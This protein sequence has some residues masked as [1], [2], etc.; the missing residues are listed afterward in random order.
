MNH[1]IKIL[2]LIFFLNIMIA[3]D[4]HSSENKNLLT[5]IPAEAY[6]LYEGK[7]S[8]NNGDF[9]KAISLFTVSYEKLPLLADYALLWR[10]EAYEKKGDLEL[11]IDDLRQLRENFKD[12]IFIKN[13]RK[14]ELQLNLNIKSP[15]ASVLLKKY[16]NDY[17]DDMD[18]KYL[19]ADSQ[20]NKGEI[21]D[22]KKIFKEIFLSNSHLSIAARKELSSEDIT[23]RDLLKKGENLNKAYLFKEAEKFFREALSKKGDEAR[24]EIVKGLADSLFRQKRYK[25]SGDL[26]RKIRNQYWLARSLLRAG[27]LKAFES[28]IANL[29]KIPDSRIGNVLISYGNRKRRAGDTDTAFRI[30]K[31]ISSQ[32]ASLKEE[33]LW[34]SGW[35]YYMMRDYVNAYKIF[36]QLHEAYADSRYAYWK[37]KSLEL[38][39]SSE[40]VKVAVKKDFNERDYYT[41]LHI[42]KNKG[43]IPPVT[44]P[45]LKINVASPP[46]QKIDIMRKL[47]FKKEAV[48][49]LIHLSR[50]KPDLS[51]LLQISLQLKD[52]GNYKM[53]INML[54]RGSYKSD[55]HELFYPLAFWAE[56]QEASRINNIDPHLIISVMR[57]ESR[58]DEE[59]RSIAGAIGLM[60]LMPQT[61]SRLSNEMNLYRNSLNLYNPEVNIMLGSHYLKNLLKEFKSLPAAIAAYNAG[62]NAVREWLKSSNYKSADEFIEDIPYDETRNYVKKVLASYLQY[63]R[64]DA[65]IDSSATLKIIL[66]F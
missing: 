12:S 52:L 34:A 56:I 23:T 43:S 65:G 37:T 44:N 21:K 11:A 60:Q 29:K 64:T 14:K 6:H 1:F 53:S 17:P 32:H 57:E 47:G 49:E 27:D 10:S 33:A 46:M 58:F 62:E 4:I 30:F 38:S 39:G 42:I 31:E 24:D 28:E 41:M 63:Q 59:A 8:L 7:K 66:G 2:L 40:P 20:K 13:V 19:Y 22:A 18:M 54:S 16:V 55:L 48:Q 45:P 26:Y 15:T 9:D 51:M 50:K 61:A 35:T 36:S 3:A 5:S 25:E